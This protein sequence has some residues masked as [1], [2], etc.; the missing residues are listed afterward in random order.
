MTS[1]K[2]IL[3]SGAL[4]AIIPS[5]SYA[6]LG[7]AAPLPQVQQ[8]TGPTLE[9]TAKWMVDKVNSTA[10]TIHWLDNKPILERISKIKIQ[11]CEIYILLRQRDVDPRPNP[12][13]ADYTASFAN[14]NDLNIDSVGISYAEDG[15]PQKGQIQPVVMSTLGEQNLIQ[16]VSQPILLYTK[17]SYG[18]HIAEMD[19]DKAFSLLKF[20]RKENIPN[21]HVDIQYTH[22][23]SYISIR[24]Q[25]L[26]TAERFVS[27]TKHMISL[28]RAQHLSQSKA[29]TKSPDEPF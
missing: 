28:C 8:P 23:T 12:S 1:L 22:F 17:N 27:A 7:D 21:K 29:P 25:D 9:E 24:F 16:E 4:I 2:S 13:W 14:F 20:I 26:G 3:F 6:Q 5:A 15:D 18:N 11:D 10:T 19:F